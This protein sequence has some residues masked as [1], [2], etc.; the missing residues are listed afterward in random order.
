MLVNSEQAT[1]KPIYRPIKSRPLPE[2]YQT[3]IDEQ[4]WQEML[5]HRLLLTMSTGARVCVQLMRLEDQTL[6][7]REPKKAN[8]Y[9]IQKSS[10][11]AVHK[12]SWECTS[13]SS[14]PAPEGVIPGVST[15]LV[16][17]ALNVG[18]ALAFDLGVNKDAQENVKFGRVK[19]Y[20]YAVLGL[21]TAVLSAPIAGIAGYSASRDLR[22]RGLPWARWL[23]WGL[24]GSS[25][26]LQGMWIAAYYGDVKQLQT[27]GTTLAGAGASLLGAIF[28]SIDAL[29]LRRQFY[30]LHRQDAMPTKAG[31]S[32]TWGFVL[33]PVPAQGQGVH[34]GVHG[35][36]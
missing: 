8:L 15:S 18:M 33:Q 11:Q 7:V 22:V 4:T 28:L 32:V 29:K 25:L 9:S 20:Q 23:G 36:F 24:Y 12:D 14:K 5:S 19:P 27:P 10:I 2:Y 1:Y 13:D 35:A 31:K 30:D 17:A 6:W 34:L 16:L 26:A 3:P 21:P